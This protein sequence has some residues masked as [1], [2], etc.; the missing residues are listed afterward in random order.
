MLIARLLPSVLIVCTT[1]ASAQLQNRKSASADPSV[2]YGASNPAGQTER[3]P[4][5]IIPDPKSEL[6]FT[7]NPQSQDGSKPGHKL[8]GHRLTHEEGFRLFMKDQSFHPPLITLLPGGEYTTD[9]TCY[10]IRSYVVARDDKDT[11]ST[12]SVG[13][14]TCQPASRYRVKSAQERAVSPDR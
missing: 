6:L 13:S 14:S 9:S 7:P 10:S 12:H 1:I 11:D 2:S 8:T 5:Q 4:W 3:E